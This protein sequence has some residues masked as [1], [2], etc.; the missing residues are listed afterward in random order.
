ITAGAFQTTDPGAAYQSQTVFVSKLNPAGTALVYSTYLGGNGGE[1]ASGIAVDAAGDAFVAGQTAS[2]NFPVTP[3]A[4]QTANKGA[5]SNKI[6]AFVTELNPTG[7]GLIY[8]TY[9]GGSILDG[10][11]AI[12]IDA[13]GNAYVAGQT[14]SSDFPVTTGAFQTVN[15]SSSTEDSNAFVAKLN[16]GGTALIYST[17]L[18]GSGGQ[19]MHEGGCLSAMATSNSILGWPIGNNEDGAFAIAVDAA[20][21]AFVAGQALSTDF[22]VTQGAFQTRNNGAHTNAT[23]AFVAKLNPA[24]SR[25]I[26]S[27]Y[28][29]GSGTACPSNTAVGYDGDTALALAVDSSGDAYLAGFTFSKD[30]PVSPGAFQTTNRFSYKGGPG[31]TAFVAKLDP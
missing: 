23:N 17:F 11:T 15:K 5:T 2:L 13:A 27:T 30:F 3:G 25:L 9:L 16:S 14:S 29:G 31:P 12:A 21:D 28:L 8:S 4:L 24:G 18:G 19:R 10:A 7:T 20:G 1:Q 6:T 26:Y 22:P